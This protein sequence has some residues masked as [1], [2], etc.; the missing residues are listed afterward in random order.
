LPLRDYRG[1]EDSKG[2]VLSAT[3]MAVADEIASAAGLVMEK[4]VRYRL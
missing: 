1:R 3:V 2:L 4:R